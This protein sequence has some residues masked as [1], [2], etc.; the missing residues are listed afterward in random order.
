[1]RT[2]VAILLLLVGVIWPLASLLWLSGRL[3]RQ[4][5]LS[6]RRLGLIIAVTGVFP[7]SLVLTAFGFLLPQFQESP[8]FKVVVLV[9]W[10]ATIALFIGLGW[11]SAMERSAAGSEKG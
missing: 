5:A 8:I 9:S 10:V 7:I 3:N 4:P 11:T 1:M 2:V 6:P